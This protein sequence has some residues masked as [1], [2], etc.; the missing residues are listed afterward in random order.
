MYIIYK[1]EFDGNVYIGS[2]RSIRERLNEHNYELR[3]ERKTYQLLYRRAKEVG[4]ECF[5]DSNCEILET[6]D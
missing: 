4:V 6:V 3:K 2:T 5:D 1:I